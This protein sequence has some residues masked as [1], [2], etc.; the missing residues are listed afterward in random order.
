MII[1]TIFYNLFAG[2]LDYLTSLESLS[3]FL[4]MASFWRALVYQLF[5]GLITAILFFNLAVALTKKLK[6]FFLEKK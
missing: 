5:W 4:I 1:S 6:P 3:F 2:F